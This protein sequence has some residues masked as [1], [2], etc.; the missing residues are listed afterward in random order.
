MLSRQISV[1]GIFAVIATLA[2][3]DDSVGP[4][5]NTLNSTTTPLAQ[6]SDRQD[7]RQEISLDPSSDF[8]NAEGKA[9]FRDRGDERQL[10][11]EV[12]DIEPGTV[13]DYFVDGTQVGTETANGLGNAELRINS[14]EGDAV[15]TSPGMIEAKTGGTLIVSGSF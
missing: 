5:E 12:E 9:K 10:E 4:N 6:G 13:V 3:C 1:L 11:I 14:D 7:N 15:P 2:A 8:P